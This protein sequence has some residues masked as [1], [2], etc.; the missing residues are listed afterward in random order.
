MLDGTATLQAR[1]LHKLRRFNVDLRG[2]DVTSVRVNGKASAFTRR[3]EQELEITPATPLI[4]GHAFTARVSYKGVPQTVIDPDGSSEGW[5]K[6]PDG[7]F[8]VVE[9]QGSPGWFPANDDPNDKATFDIAV[10]V[11]AGKTA[12]ANI[13][14][15]ASDID[16]D[17]VIA[18]RGARAAVGDLYESMTD[19]F[20]GSEA[21]AAG[22][23]VE[24]QDDAPTWVTATGGD[25]RLVAENGGVKMFAVRTGEDL[26]IGIGSSYSQTDFG[27]NGPSG[28]RAV[29]YVA[30]AGQWNAAAAGI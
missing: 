10:S 19:W 2:F 28:T 4:T 12:L 15:A 29:A 6:T 24:A 16:R 30:A 11:P 5:V 14:V 23:P 22:R 20:A 7:A 9:P 27:T 3:G 8:V 18:A 25:R 26:S 17:L 21:A 13:P 1:A